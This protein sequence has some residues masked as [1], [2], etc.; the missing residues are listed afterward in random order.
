M[1][2]E[3]VAA[4]EGWQWVVKGFKLTK[5]AV[6]PLCVIMLCFVVIVLIPAIIPKIGG[7][8]P[9]LMT[10]FLSLG[11]TSAFRL[12]A[13]GEQPKPTAL[14]EGARLGNDTAKRLFQ[15]GLINLGAS[16][17]ILVITTLIDG[18][19][20]MGWA[21][22]AITLSDPQLKDPRLMTSM[23]IFLLLLVPLQAILWYAPPFTAW[24]K[25]GVAQSLFYSGIAVWRNKG[26]FALFALVWLAIF[27]FMMLFGA[28]QSN[29]L[30]S[31]LGMNLGSA[32]A[33]FLFS[34][35][36][37]FVMTATYASFWFTYESL[38]ADENQN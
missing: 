15:L 10:P 33:T 31:V 6:L 23:P 20:L 1:K 30:T 28:L 21:T 8:V 32:A 38:K 7:F 3:S 18:G 16:L 29:F 9:F 26:A 11:L 37:L 35:V 25:V 17:L 22:G 5:A 12:A 19:I 14:F 2:I 34:A 27:N 13:K 4:R 36:S 24:H